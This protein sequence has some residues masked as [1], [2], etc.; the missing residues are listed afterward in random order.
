MNSTTPAPA[1]FTSRRIFGAAIKATY[2]RGVGQHNA[3]AAYGR[4]VHLRLEA[5]PAT[6]RREVL[7][8]GAHVGLGGGFVGAAL[9]G[10][11][12]LRFIRQQVAVRRDFEDPR[13]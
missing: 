5:G 11:G 9:G 1:H 10:L 2:R 12:K 3:P 13:D 6:S 7:G 8:G 4:F